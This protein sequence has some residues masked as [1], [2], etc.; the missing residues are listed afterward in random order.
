MKKNLPISGKEQDY[1]DKTTII[2]TTDIKGIITYVNQGFVEVS[3]FTEQELLG[4]NHNIVRHPDMPPVAFRDLWDTVKTGKPWRGIVKNRCKNGDHYWVDAYVTP[5]YEGGKIVGY[6]SVRSKPK[7]VQIE[8][9][10]KL[11]KKL[12]QSNV[13]KLIKPWRPL[14]MP[15]DGKVLAAFVLM[16]LLAVMAG[17]AG[18]NGM[19]AKDAV[20]H[21][22]VES[23]TTHLQNL[24]RVWEEQASLQETQSSQAQARMASEFAAIRAQLGQAHNRVEPA[25]GGVVIAA[26]GLALALAVLLTLLN[27]RMLTV[28]LLRAMDSAK[29]IAGGDLTQRVDIQNNDELGQVLQAVKM[30]QARL[31]T[32]IGRIAE[33]TDSLAHDAS[34]VSKVAQQSNEGMRAQHTETD[35]VATAMNQM[36]A[37]VQ[38]VA[39]HAQHAA[40][41][42]TAATEDVADGKQVMLEVSATINTL[43]QEVEKA[44]T[45]M[46]Q[47]EQKSEEI[48][49]ILDVIRG[50]AEQTNLLALNAAIEA[51]RAGEQGRG[52]AVVADE[53]RGL[54]QRTQEATQQIQQMIEGLQVEAR[55]AAGLMRRGQEQVRNSVDSA[56][57]A[58]T[59]LDN[60]TRRIHQI[61]DLN[62]QIATAAE[63]QSAVSEEINRNITTIATLAEQTEEGSARTATC[64]ISL[65]DQTRELRKLVAQFKLN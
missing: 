3:G 44:G 20:L 39:L 21:G 57:R 9:A 1:S 35:M 11:Y 36:S 26:M 46:T 56:G 63:Q 18:L 34:E 25:S 59:A 45:V 52:F 60:I 12:L 41:A 58:G 4:K 13:E 7:R 10:E 15:V 31:Q 27:R 24:Q 51:A 2:S 28:P 50:I 22:Q 48:G 49:S 64:C 33:F 17:V 19:R 55:G 30:M 37:A 38:E 42:A 6:Q 14:D 53:V 8:G 32:V 23:M 65:A 5:L 40:D 43:A 54:A 29:A 47:L 16:A 62:T 61:N